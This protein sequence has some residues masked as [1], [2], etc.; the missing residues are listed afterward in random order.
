MKT[1]EEFTSEGF[2][3]RPSELQELSI[4]IA[5]IEQL[6]ANKKIDTFMLAIL[7]NIN[8]EINAMRDK[9]C[10]RLINLAKQGNLID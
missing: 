8:A 6:K 1:K 4:L 2:Y 7:T 10:W 5:Q 3:L 9:I